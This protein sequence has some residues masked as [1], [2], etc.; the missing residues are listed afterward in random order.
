MNTANS[1]P[2]YDCVVIGGGIS[3]ISFAYYL[4]K[5]GKKALIIEKENRIGGQISSSFSK[6]DQ[7]YW[8]EL[9]A[10][11]CYNS[12]TYFL[13]LLEQSGCTSD[14]IDLAK[15]KY[16]LY[17]DDKLKSIFSE[18]SLLSMML[19]CT[20]IFFSD[21]KDKTVKE[22][23]APIVGMSN[24]NH[25]FTHAFKAVISQNADDYPAELFLKKRKEK[26]Q[27]KPRRFSSSKGLSSFLDSIVRNNNLDTIT[28]SEVTDIKKLNSEEALNFDY[29]GDIYEVKT[30]NNTS[31]YTK[32]VALATDPQLS[33]TLLKEIDAP[34]STLLATIPL[35]HS[36]S[37]NIIVKKEDISAKEMAGIIPLSNE[38][39]SAVSRDL[40]THPHLRS[41][42][43]HFE[44]GK[45]TK[46]EQLDLICHVLGISKNIILESDS[47]THVL[48]MLRKE[49]L[50]MSDR[51]ENQRT[52]KNIFILGNYFYGLSI[53]DC[54]RRSHTEFERY[55]KQ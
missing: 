14:I 43:F 47:T 32:N 27:D 38:F 31:F 54:V 7:N 36:E 12:Y 37:L 15:H 2:L 28:N 49:H 21:R 11:T 8:R 42:T 53:E 9:G 3:G 48:P 19:H 25:L 46:E 50:N 13:S 30:A 22:Y 26:Q 23:F 10:H 1:T 4:H 39:F 34:L 35:F 45:K 24:Y 40:V 6:V 33:S 55:T 41:F 51:I 17:A 44:R 18:L 29:L 52:N 5:M 16:L 20:R